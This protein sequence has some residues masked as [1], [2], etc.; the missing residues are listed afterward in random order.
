MVS[1]FSVYNTVPSVV[2]C[3][4]IPNGLSHIQILPQLQVFSYLCG[5]V[6]QFYRKFQLAC[7]HTEHKTEACLDPS[8]VP[9]FKCRCGAHAISHIHTV[10]PQLGP[11]GCGDKYSDSRVTVGV[12][13]C[14]NMLQLTG[15]CY[16][17]NLKSHEAV[18]ACICLRTM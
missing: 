17:M 15:S 6:T 7:R 4:L 5:A 1:H 2:V 12:L 18:C 10:M 11:K 14:C 3:L 13:C 8:A 9:I 16:V